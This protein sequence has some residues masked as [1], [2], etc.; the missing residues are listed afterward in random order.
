M[1]L[2]HHWHHPLHPS[3]PTQLTHLHHHHHPSLSS[4]YSFFS[5]WFLFLLLFLLLFCGRKIK[6]FNSFSVSISSIILIDS[7]HSSSPLSSLY[8]N[9]QTVSAAVCAVKHLFPP[10]TLWCN[11][12]P[13]RGSIVVTSVTLNLYLQ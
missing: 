13:N 6:E 7:T 10:S 3:L 11:A 5:I 8:T 2:P 9:P 1:E 4:M 12:T